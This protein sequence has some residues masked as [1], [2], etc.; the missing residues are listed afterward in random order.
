LVE[1]AEKNKGRKPDRTI[2]DGSYDS[3]RNF[4]YLDS[5]GIEPVIKTRKDASTK[6]RGPLRELK[7]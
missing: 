6:A 3:R 5:N 2:A 1:K 4:N 7:W